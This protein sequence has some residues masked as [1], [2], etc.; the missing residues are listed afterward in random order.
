MADFTLSGS[1]ATPSS[2]SEA[3]RTVT[4]KSVLWGAARRCG[5]KPETRDLTP[6]RAAQLTEFINERVRE[7][8]EYAEW[9]DLRWIEQRYYHQGLWAAGSY[10]VGSIVYE[11]TSE[12]Y[13]TADTGTTEQ[14]SS[15]ATD[16]TVNTTYS[17]H[18]PWTQLNQTKIG[19]VTGCWKSNP[20]VNR[21]PTPL[22]YETTDREGIYIKDTEAGVSVYLEFLVREPEFTSTVHSASTSYSVGDLVYY[23][24]TGECYQALAAG[25]VADPSASANWDLQEFPYAFASFVKRAAR[26]DYLDS[27]EQFD[28][29]EKEEMR[30]FKRLDDLLNRGGVQQQ[31]PSPFVRTRG[32]AVR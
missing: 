27:K 18:I 11:S 1:I 13:Y 30:A 19:N 16:W 14:P 10:A 9:P 23:P 5:W 6:E 3:L 20:R 26:A 31:L 7:A 8:W 21:T 2:T 24:T 15:T 29:A 12:A 4:F 25:T 32:S 17:K 22:Y 28:L